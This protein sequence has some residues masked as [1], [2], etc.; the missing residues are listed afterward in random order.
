ML[1]P[2]ALG[3][4]GRQGWFRR[5]VHELEC[6]FCSVFS[7]VVDPGAIIPVA[8]LVLHA[9]HLDDARPCSAAPCC[10]L[11]PAFFRQHDV[12]MT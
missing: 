3:C 1:D 7:G 4:R 6:N 8:R 9:L 2:R 5:D 11:V 10:S 12:D